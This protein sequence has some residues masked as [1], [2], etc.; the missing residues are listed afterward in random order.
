MKRHRK[1]HDCALQILRKSF[2]FILRIF[3]SNEAM[4]KKQKKLS[5]LCNLFRSFYSIYLFVEESRGIIMP[6]DKA[7]L[8]FKFVFCFVSKE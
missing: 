6:V 5:I 8:I 4:H 3:F 2:I 1:C 7:Y